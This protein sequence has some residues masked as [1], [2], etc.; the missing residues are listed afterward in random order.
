MIISL[1]LSLSLNNLKLFFLPTFQLWVTWRLYYKRQVLF[2]LRKHLC[3]HPVFG[4][5]R[6]VY[7][8]SF[9]CCVFVFYFSSSCVLCTLYCQFLWIVHFLIAP[10]V[11]PDVYLS[12]DTNS[13]KGTVL[14]LLLYI[15]FVWY[16][17]IYENTNTQKY[18][19]MT[20]FTMILR[21]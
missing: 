17:F 11:F 8:F 9:L 12:L 20:H 1:Y 6:V 16:A 14:L 15:Q 2:T 4:G 3:S 18:Q 21:S 10:L 7:L 5:F 19:V 13:S